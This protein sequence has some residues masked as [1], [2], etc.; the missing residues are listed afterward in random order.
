M[1]YRAKGIC[2]ITGTQRQ[3][4]SYRTSHISQAHVVGYPTRREESHCCE[5]LHP[6]D[7]YEYEILQGAYMCPFYIFDA[8][9]S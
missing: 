2:K 6:H 5:Y 8:Q 4:K 1:A 3:R 9:N 7:W